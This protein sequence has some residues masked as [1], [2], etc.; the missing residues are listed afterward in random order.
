MKCSQIHECRNLKQGRAVL[1]LGIHKSDFA[2]L[3]F[4]TNAI[5]R[6]CL[7]STRVRLSAWKDQQ[8]TKLH[9]MLFL[10]ILSCVHSTSQDGITFY[11]LGEKPYIFFS[12]EA[13]VVLFLIKCIVNSIV[14][15]RMCLVSSMHSI[16]YF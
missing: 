9:Y 11:S 7:E 16:V 10:N 8:N 13:L 6:A 4:S 1:F 5:I 15:I 12:F 14:K 3:C 2:T